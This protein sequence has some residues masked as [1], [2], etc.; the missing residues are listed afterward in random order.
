MALKLTSEI[1]SSIRA[2]FSLPEF[3]LNFDYQ[4]RAALNL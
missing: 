3:A 4:E 2:A 1:G